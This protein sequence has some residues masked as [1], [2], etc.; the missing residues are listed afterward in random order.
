M[1][2]KYKLYR[3]DC[4]EIMDEL[5]KKNIKIDMILTDLPYSSTK[6]KWDLM[7]PFEPMWERI[8]KLI[9][10]NG[11]IILFGDGLFTSKLML[12]NEKM[13]RYNLIWDK[14]RGCDFLNANR[15]PMKSHEDILV[16]YK[17]LPTYNKQY[18]YSIPYKPK[19]NYTLSDNYGKRETAISESL[20]GKRNPLT[21]LS[22]P[23][24]GIKLHPTQKPIALLEYLIK[25]YSNEEDIV[26]DFT[27]GVGSTGVACLNTNRK[28]IGIELDENYFN[29]AKERID[30]I[31]L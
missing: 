31:G 26:L 28:F 11:A 15:K 8:N 16:F 4:L 20:D 23:K 9:K 19:R 30:K 10:D 27:M 21:I 24:D 17:K 22:F 1:K 6:N 18:W 29:V 5:I 7:I 25:T 12:S 14:Q 13:W 2:N 3:G